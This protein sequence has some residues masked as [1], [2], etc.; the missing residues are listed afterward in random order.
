MA[1]KK[2]TS[3]VNYF[4]YLKEKK[5][6][7]KQLVIEGIGKFISLQNQAFTVL[8]HS[9]PLIYLLDYTT[10]RYVSFSKQCNAVLNFSIEKI[11]DGGI[12][13]VLDR[14]HPDDF[15]LFNNQ[16]FTDRLR[17]LKGIPAEQHKD[18]IFSYNYRI[19]N[20]KGEYIN[21]LQRNS[22]IQSDEEGNPL[23]SMGVLTNIIHFQEESPVIQLVEKIDRLTGSIQLVNKNTYYLRE[24]DK[25]FTKREKEILLYLADGLTSKQIADKLFLSENTVINHKRNMHFKSNTQNSAALISFAFRKYQL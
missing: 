24:E 7:S 3:W 5:I 4:E 13:F 2:V 22:F 18:H 8:N 19:K 17:I 23:I 1:V 11:L 20:G 15:R 10:G 21:L 12:G 6:T 14:Y 9:V 16:I 25:I